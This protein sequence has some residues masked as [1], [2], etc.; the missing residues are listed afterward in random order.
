M[1]FRKIFDMLHITRNGT[2]TK[3]V[4]ALLLGGR[5]H[6]P[7]PVPKYEKG[8]APFII[9]FSQR[10]NLPPDDMSWDTSQGTRPVSVQSH[11]F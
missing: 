1:T 4:L 11:V 6:V 7:V 2:D 9:V 8:H 10:W 3:L 5:G